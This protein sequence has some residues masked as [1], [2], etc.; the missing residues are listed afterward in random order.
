MPAKTRRACDIASGPSAFLRPASR[1]ILIPPAV[2]AESAAVDQRPRGP[3]A[4]NPAF[5]KTLA[6]ATE[7]PSIRPPLNLLVKQSSGNQPRTAHKPPSPSCFCSWGGLETTF[8]VAVMPNRSSLTSRGLRSRL[9]WTCRRLVEVL[10]RTT[11]AIAVVNSP[12]HQKSGVVGSVRPAQSGSSETRTKIE[13]SG[14]QAITFSRAARHISLWP[15]RL[16]TCGLIISNSIR[17]ACTTRRLFAT[18]PAIGQAS[19]IARAVKRHSSLVRIK[20]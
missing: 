20:S 15:K 6:L 11:A 5:Q 1:S 7:I 4:C 14:D 10:P 2:T 8:S 9:T 18:T 3:R 12:S 16:D 17:A 13:R 19:P